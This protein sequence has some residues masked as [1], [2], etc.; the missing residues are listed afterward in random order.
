MKNTSILVV[1]DDTL[2]F[3]SLKKILENLGYANLSHVNNGMDAIAAVKLLNYD[4]VLMDIL[5]QHFDL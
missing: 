2:S 4:I 5:F 3:E 1:E